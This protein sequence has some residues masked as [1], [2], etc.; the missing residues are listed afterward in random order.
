MKPLLAWKSS[1]LNSRQY[2][3]SPNLSVLRLGRR[4]PDP[5]S[6]ELARMWLS[7]AKAG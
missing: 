5:A 2:G 7:A 4:G 6:P 3:I 1:V